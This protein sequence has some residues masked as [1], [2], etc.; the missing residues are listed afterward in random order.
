MTNPFNLEYSTSLSRAFEAALSNAGSDSWK[1]H[2]LGLD[3]ETVDDDDLSLSMDLIAEEVEEFFEAVESFSKADVTKELCDCLV[4]L[5]R[6]AVKYDLPI[7]EAYKRVYENNMGKAKYISVREDGK[8]VKP[9]NY[10]K[11]KLDDLFDGA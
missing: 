6:F 2:R 9:F 11:V 4:V 8:V 1:L 5:L 3:L 10:P 7:N